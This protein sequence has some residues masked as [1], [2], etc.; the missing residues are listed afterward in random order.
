VP[1]QMIGVTGFVSHTI[2]CYLL[3]YHSVVL[4]YGQM[5]IE[6]CL[7]REDEKMKIFRYS[8]YPVGPEQICI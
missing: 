2:C 8:F 1:V 7:C 4:L 6:I 3:L 5:D